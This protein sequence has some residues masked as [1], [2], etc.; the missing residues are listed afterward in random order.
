MKAFLID[1]YE[2][3]VDLRCVNFGIWKKFPR[4]PRGQP[5]I[6]FFFS[7]LQQL[8]CPRV[9]DIGAGVGNFSLLAKFHPE[10]TFFAFEPLKMVRLILVSN[11]ELNGLDDRV[12]ISPY[13]LSDKDGYAKL[14]IPLDKQLGLACIGEPLRYERWTEILVEM[15]RLDSLEPGKI[16]LAKIDTEGCELLVLKGGGE[17]FRANMP[18]ILLEYNRINTRQFGYKRTEIV[19]LL[20]GWGYKNFEE[21][22]RENLWITV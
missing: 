19:K 6:E 8:E 5:L 12:N 1:G 22:N 2:V 4:R 16:D 15:R 20:K 10:A 13:A 18:P 14:K 11:V 21:I 3:E 17:T 7:K 9:L